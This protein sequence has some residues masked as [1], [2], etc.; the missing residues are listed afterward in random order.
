MTDV[1]R[2]L[3]QPLPRLVTICA[4]PLIVCPL[5]QYLAVGP[6]GS[7]VF[8][9]LEMFIIPLPLLVAL[10]ALLVA[11]FFLFFRRFRRLAVRTLLAAGVFVVATFAGVRLGQQLRMKAFHQLAVRSEPL[12][13]AIRTYET[14][15]G[16]PPPDL[17]A[18]VPDFLP[19]IP[20]TGMAAYRT[21]RY[22]ASAQATRF[23]NNPWVLVVFTPNGGINFDQFMYFPLQKDPENGYGGSLERVRDWAYVHE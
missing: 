16:A 22:H 4:S 23:D 2:F 17:N 11:P 18:L 6:V 1:Q 15:H 21:Y 19:S 14:K 13:R 9:S 7:G 5:L 20:R 3:N 8:L 10:P 12:V